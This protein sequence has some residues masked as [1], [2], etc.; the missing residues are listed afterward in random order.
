MIV[1]EE[2]RVGVD[3]LMIA[4]AQ[5]ELSMTEAER[6]M[7]LRAAGPLNAVIRPQY[8][9]AIRN[10]DGFVRSAARMGGSERVMAPRVPVLGQQHVSKMSGDVVNDGDDLVSARNR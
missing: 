2:G 9:L 8:L 4:F 5:H 10:R 6:L 7:E 1:L 3:F